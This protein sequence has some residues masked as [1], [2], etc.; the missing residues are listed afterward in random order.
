MAQLTDGQEIRKWTVLIWCLLIGLLGKI[1]I[2][3]ILFN[4]GGLRDWWGL[5][6]SQAA[7][8][9]PQFSSATLPFPRLMA[10]IQ[11]ERSALQAREEELRERESQILTLK[12]ELESRLQELVAAQERVNRLLAEE[13][14]VQDERQRHLIV[15][16]E[17][18]PA[19]QAGKLIDKLDEPLV[20]R[21]LRSMKGQEAGKILGLLEPEKAA[22]ISKQLFN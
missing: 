16:L 8:A 12:Q 17:S 2:S 18:M 11:E 6:K 14:K 15:T 4:L 22:R 19:E 1:M 9:E 3:A 20:G 7:A 5:E 10:M 21:L 13:G